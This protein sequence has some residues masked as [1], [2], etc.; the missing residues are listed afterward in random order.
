MANVQIKG[1]KVNGVPYDLNIGEIVSHMTSPDGTDYIL[2]VDNEGNLYCAENVAEPSALTP[3]TTAGL[4]L[5]T[6]AGKGILFINEFYCGGLDTNEHSINYC[7][8]NFVELANL[9]NSD[10]NLKGISLQYA[11]SENDWKVLPLSGVIKAGST[12][13]IRGAQC[14]K[15]SSPTTRIIVGKYDME[16]VSNGELI[17]FDSETSC[18]FYLTFNLSAYTQANPYDSAKKAVMNDAIGF[19]DL[20]GVKG[21]QDPGG[22]IGKPYSAMG[23]LSNKKLFKRYYAMDPVSQATKTIDAMD[24][25]T[26]WNFVDLTK[27][28]GEVIP[29]IGVFKPMAVSERKDIFYNKTNLDKEKPSMITCSF[30]I[31]ATDSGAGATRCFNWLTGNLEDK[32]IWIREEGSGNWGTPRTAFEK[33]DGR[34]AWSHS[35]Y[36]SIA[37]EYTNNT[38]IL[39]YKYIVSGLTAGTYEYVAGKKNNDGTPN[40][41]GCTD[42]RKFTVRASSSID[43]GFKFVQ[44]SDQQGFNWDEYQVWKYAADV[45]SKEYGGKFD[46]MINTGDM[47]QNGNRLGEWLDYFNGKSPLLNDMEEM[48]TIGNNDLS[49]NV[50]YKLGNGGDSSKLWPENITFFY[51][52]ESDP[53]NMPIF[54]GY[55]DVDYY[56]PS[57]YSFNY[58]FVH[59]LCL[60]SEI[61]KT[62][63]EGANGYNFGEGNYGNFY[64]QIK[65]WCEADMVKYG[66]TVNIAYCHEMPFTIMTPDKV[67]LSI[68]ATRAGGSSANDN[69]PVGQEYWFSEFCQTHR[70]PLVIGGH[71]HTQ[72][73]SWPLLENVKYEGS[74]RT[75]DSMHPII[76]VNDTTLALFDNATSLVEYEGRK[77]PNSWFSDGVPVGS[78]TGQVQ[79]CEFKMESELP[80]GTYPVTYAMSQ[81][82]G[83]KHTSNKELP[84]LYIPW[85]RYYYPATGV[86]SETDKAKVNVHQKFPHFT[87]WNVTKTGITGNVRKVYGAF[88]DSGKFDINVDG[89]WTRQGKCATTGAAG[90]H[91]KDMFSINGITSM[92]D[93]EAMTDSRIVEVAIPEESVN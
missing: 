85:L 29:S 18:K 2:K 81:A 30:G 6:S 23:G 47:T 42:V 65:K 53:D 91:E 11:I 89:Q 52:F 3:P 7:S 58:G 41:A 26:E 88:N 1:I 93:V 50:L 27:A 61:K 82:T 46:F 12:F 57:L 86:G 39:A 15:L 36:D 72:S 63:E 56:I 79:I 80:S 48:A 69:M 37:K 49:S 74:T 60:N 19:L 78:Y 70:I 66:A 13:V 25:T 34:S 87:V 77:Y 5:A 32:Y 14:S 17:K 28:D 20:I 21:T 24:N 84:S 43:G 83:Y 9:G 45:I 38:V 40:L 22:F 73:T 55:N 68:P 54:K 44:T 16:W 76:V 8:H 33:G 92:E 67:R 71:K 31:Q 4:A 64:P 10:I 90:G 51:T 35:I 62:A 75:V 59:F